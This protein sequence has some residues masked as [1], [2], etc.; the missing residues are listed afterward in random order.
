VASSSNGHFCSV[1]AHSPQTICLQVVNCLGFD[2]F[3]KQEVHS[4]KT[5]SWSIIGCQEIN[6]TFPS[7]MNFWR[8]DS[9]GVSGVDLRL[10]D[11]RNWLLKKLPTCF[12][13]SLEVDFGSC[14]DDSLPI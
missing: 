6:P 8:L 14:V 4:S 3:L 9:A 5:L 12:N 11:W 13:A 10:V 7:I 2:R 1:F